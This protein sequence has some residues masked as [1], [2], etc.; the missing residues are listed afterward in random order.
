[1]APLQPFTE[2]QPVA[3]TPI[4]A[5]EGVHKTDDARLAQWCPGRCPLTSVDEHLARGGLQ[6]RHTDADPEKPPVCDL[7]ANRWLFIVSSGGRTGSTTALSMLKAHPAFRLAG[8]NYGL[9]GRAY[10]MWRTAA[11]GNP[12]WN[13][14]GSNPK[15]AWEVFAATRTH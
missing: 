8:E 10:E 2:Q 6:F 5:S 11:E 7:C 9:L 3:L 14:N 4:V 15:L 13:G 1:M 12:A